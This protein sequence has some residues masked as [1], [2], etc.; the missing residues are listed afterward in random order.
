[1]YE[2]YSSAREVTVCLSTEA[3][4]G[5]SVLEWLK[6]L[7]RAFPHLCETYTVEQNAKTDSLSNGK[8]RE[9][10]LNAFTSHLESDLRNAAD[11]SSWYGLLDMLQQPWWSRAWV[12]FSSLQHTVVG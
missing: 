2:I 6:D 8:I 5:A 9:D 4:R 1:M 7:C 10:E 3:H 12:G 11:W